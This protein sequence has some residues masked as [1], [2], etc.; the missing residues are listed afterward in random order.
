MCNIDIKPKDLQVIRGFCY[1]Q[2]LTHM[3]QIREYFEKKK[4]QLITADEVAEYYG[5]PVDTVKELLNKKK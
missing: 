1:N 2:A 3:K 5:L 4:H